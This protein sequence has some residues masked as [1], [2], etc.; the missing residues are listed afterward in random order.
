MPISKRTVL[1][2]NALSWIIGSL[3]ALA[4]GWVID[5]LL[6]DGIVKTI[7]ILIFAAIAV[8]IF[9]PVARST[10]TTPNTTRDDE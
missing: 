6:A 8:T 5:R 7:A 4:G 1:S 3:V 2:V 10:L 9:V